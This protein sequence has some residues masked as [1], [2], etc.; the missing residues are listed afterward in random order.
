MWEISFSCSLY[1]HYLSIWMSLRFFPGKQSLLIYD[2][3]WGFGGVWG[4][5]ACFICRWLIISI[6]ASISC[7]AAALWPMTGWMSSWS[8]SWLPM[9]Q[10]RSSPSRCSLLSLLSLSSAFARDYSFEWLMIL[11]P[12]AGESMNLF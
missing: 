2:E 11:W 12:L 7:W 6:N 8:P 1:Y 10:P 9:D 5:L 3:E 4:G